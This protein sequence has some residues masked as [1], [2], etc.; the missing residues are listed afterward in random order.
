MGTNP[1]EGLGALAHDTTSA[2]RRSRTYAIAARELAGIAVNLVA[3]PLGVLDEAL[4]HAPERRHAPHPV[5]NSRFFTNPAAFDV[6]VLLVHGY[7]HNRSG[8]LVLRNRLRRRGFAGLYT[9]NYNALVQD[10]PE[11]SRRLAH[12]VERICDETRQPFVNLV[13]HS[14]GGIVARSYVQRLGGDERVLRAITI[15]SPHNGTHSA[16]LFSFLGPTAK[17]LAWGSSLISSLNT[18]VTPSPVLWTS[19]W[20]PSDEL[21]VPAESAR[22]CPTVFRAEN[23]MIPG[24]GH[25]SLLIS[26]RVMDIVVDRLG[27]IDDHPRLSEDHHPLSG[28]GSGAGAG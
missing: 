7:A 24:H 4:E 23:V 16:S 8:Y 18:S 14:L 17:Q 1:P 28:A 5:R 27:D 11:I 13:G 26:P 9:L 10:V 25:M 22:L 6:P 21:V 12:R 20:S 2:L 19:I 15:G 3:Y